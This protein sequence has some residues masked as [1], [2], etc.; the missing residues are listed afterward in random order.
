MPSKCLC[1]SGAVGLHRCLDDSLNLVTGLEGG[2]VPFPVPVRA[3]VAQLTAADPMTSLI[4]RGLTPM[5]MKV[6]GA[7]E[8]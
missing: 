3:Q 4:G 5:T 1:C 8:G 6:D 2:A 7:Q